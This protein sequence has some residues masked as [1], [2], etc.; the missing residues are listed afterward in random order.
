MHPI[1]AHHDSGYSCRDRASAVTCSSPE[2]SFVRCWYALYSKV[3]EHQSRISS[4]AWDL[5]IHDTAVTVPI[6]DIIVSI[7]H[8]RHYLLTLPAPSTLLDKM[9]LPSN[10]WCGVTHQYADNAAWSYNC[11]KLALLQQS[12]QLHLCLLAHPH[13]QGWG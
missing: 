6:N 11:T 2:G 5:L 3:A 10:P 13:K 4:S 7:A 9:V 8:Q 1:L 12:R